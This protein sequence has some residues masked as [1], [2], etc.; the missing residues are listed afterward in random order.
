M[1]KKNNLVIFF[2]ILLVI[3]VQSISAEKIIRE[4]QKESCGPAGCITVD[5]P[6][7]IQYDTETKKYEFGLMVTGDKEYDI[8]HNG[9]KYKLGV[10][11]YDGKAATSY[12][13]QMFLNEGVIQELAS[14]QS[15]KIY[16]CISE[17]YGG[18]NYTGGTKYIGIFYEEIHYE[19]L[20]DKLDKPKKNCYDISSNEKKE[21]DGSI[22]EISSCPA[23]QGIYDDI[24]DN[25]SYYKE[26]NYKN[27]T[28]ISNA[29]NLINKIKGLCYNILAYSDV[30]RPCTDA[31]LNFK[32]QLTESKKIYGIDTSSNK[33]EYCG[34]SQKLALYIRNIVKWVKYIIPVI[35]I[36]LGILDF[37][38]AIAADKEDE[39]KKAQGRFVKRLIAAALI[40][41]VPLIIGFVLD[42][43]GFEEYVSGC[44][45]IDL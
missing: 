6:F 5:K 27:T 16:Y 39:I 43:M 9:N 22:E 12:S 34:F 10:Y 23:Y 3:N 2:L 38:K 19:S 14:N 1:F 25:Y 15:L 13:F 35:V 40:F 32:N 44:G 20:K 45:I 17:E 42:K 7:I 31:C 37:I 30:G 18:G 26:S 4:Y 29:N 28:F 21:S 36:V 8:E 41:I 33:K 24:E 11:Y